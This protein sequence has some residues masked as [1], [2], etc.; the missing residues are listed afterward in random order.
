MTEFGGTKPAQALAAQSKSDLWADR[1]AE[2]WRRDCSL[3]A[4]RFL[5]LH[6]E[7]VGDGLLI[8]QV[9]FE[10]FF[11]RWCAGENVR[12]DSLTDQFPECRD[13]LGTLIAIFNIAEHVPE[14]RRPNLSSMTV[15][16]NPPERLICWPLVGETIEGFRLVELIGQGR[17]SRV[18]LAE[19]PVLGDRQ[20]IVK[21]SYRDGGEAHA[22][23]K[24]RHP[25]IVDVY[26]VKPWPAEKL[27]LICMPFMGR[28]TL[29]A[30]LNRLSRRN[31]LPTRGSQLAA[32]FAAANDPQFDIEGVDRRVLWAS[33][34]DAVMWLGVQLAEALSY[35]HQRGICHGDL[36]PSNILIDAR[37]KPMLLDF[38]LARQGSAELGR[39]G[40]TIPYMPPEIMNNLF[41]PD[42]PG[43][44]EVGVR[45]DLYSLAIVL[46]ELLCGDLPFIRYDELTEADKPTARKVLE[47]QQQGPRP[48]LPRNPD[49][50]PVLAALIE[51][52]LAIDLDKRPASAEELADSLRRLSLR[53]ARVSRL[54]LRHRR[55]FVGL[56]IP[57][58]A[59]TTV[60]SSLWATAPSRD[61]RAFADAQSAR[62]RGDYSTALS[63]LADAETHGFDPRPL[64]E[65]RAQMFYQL[66]QQAFSEQ[67]FLAARDYATKTL[68][69]GLRDWRTHLLRGRARLHLREVELA[70]EDLQEASRFHP[71]PRISAA[72]GD[73]LCLLEKWDLA[74]AAYQRAM[75]EGISSAALANNL[76]YALFRRGDRRESLEW[77]NQAIAGDGTLADAHYLRALLV[78]AFAGEAHEGIPRQARD[79]IDRAIQLC[80]ANYRVFFAAAGIYSL[81]A[82][83]QVRPELRQRAR[84]C[85]YESLRLGLSASELPASG[86]L[87]QLVR[88]ERGSSDY[89]AAAAQ[90]ARARRSRALGLV[91]SLAGIGL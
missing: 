15:E 56:A 51:R 4:R 27:T 57:L 32:A 50:G 61:Q 48:L 18:Y 11:Q 35:T 70:R 1:F 12:P 65:L 3:S 83:E 29:E 47:L 17:F 19:E 2:A 63:R 25:N 30:V 14:L 21:A 5:T 90:G 42:G 52:C 72:L 9:A 84:D 68:D 75:R 34:V 59:S 38:N 58:A 46:Y 87:A 10:E 43:P 86:A 71:D 16:V 24:L 39:L 13:E 44:N 31:S 6:P 81:S 73:C 91:D 85:F 62:A 54:L 8:A 69:A 26:S 79:D 36:K 41:F 78:T 80:P 20:V 64:A 45:S 28:T 37:G 82:A 74:V 55:L 67:E 23:G 60:V 76:G 53:R 66:A 49:V 89:Q 77:L 40:G 88:H 33:Y 22:L 7:I